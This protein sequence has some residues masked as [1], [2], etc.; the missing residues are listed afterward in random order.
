MRRELAREG[1][2]FLRD[3]QAMATVI[4]AALLATLAVGLGLKDIALQNEE[5]ASLRTSTLAD[6]KNTLSDQPDPGSAA[7]YGFRLVY[8]PPGE[9]AFAARGVRDQLPW[10]HRLRIL[11]LEGQIYENDT[12]NPELGQIGRIDFAFLI[13]VLAPLFVILMLH[14]VV[15]SE[16][17]QN[18]LDL[19]AATAADAGRLVRWRAVVRTVALAVALLLPFVVAAFWSGANPIDVLSLS[20]LGFL[21]LAGW[22]AVV[23][24]T[25]GRLGSAATSAA[26]LL[27]LWTTLV[28]VVPLTAGAIAERSIAVPQGGEILLQQRETVNRAWD[29]PEEVTMEAF[30]ATHPEWAD[31]TATGDGFDWKWYYAFQQVGDQSVAEMSAALRDGVRKRD[32]F[33]Q[34]VSYLSPPLLVDR[35]FARVAGTDIAAFQR[36]DA[37][38]RDFHA[39]LRKAHYPMLFGAEAFDLAALLA[40]ENTRECRQATP[41]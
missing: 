37:C 22:A 18:R 11:A 28:L 16:R 25:A 34:K 26:V 2:F 10:K 38:V 40:L 30:V 1:W 7:Y 6:L 35:V 29:L 33:M 5:I 12:G 14:D 27:G 31:Y 41:L 39:D 17:R 20:A 24:W 19:L 23:T 32:E 9:L 36:Y 4:A 8:D 15:D 3:R 21:Y 13:S